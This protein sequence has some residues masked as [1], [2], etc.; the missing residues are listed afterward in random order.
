MT[1]AD[2]T[3]T[4]L[5]GLLS[6]IPDDKTAVIIPEQ[7]IRVTYGSLRRQVETVAEAL[8]AS[9]VKRGDRVGIALPNG[10]PT[11]VSFLAASVAGTAA[12]LNPGYK[13]DEFRFY[14]EDT[15]ARVL[16]LPPDGAE[17][18]RRAAGDRV[19]ILSVEMDA[20]GTVSLSG[21]TRRQPVAAP[22]VDPAHERQHRTAEACAAQSREPL[23][24]GGQRGEKLR[25]LAG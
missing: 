1:P 15:N 13:E 19:P 21:V 3:P 22:A 10:L 25:A 2:A 17:E 7:N 23:D 14:L 16:L 20:E 8:A 24:L 11:I 4:T 18:A 9:G 6:P 5:L 12:P